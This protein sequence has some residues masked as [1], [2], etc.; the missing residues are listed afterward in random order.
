MKPPALPSRD[1][2]GGHG[3]GPFRRVR[4]GDGVPGF[5]APLTLWLSMIAAV[6]L[7]ARAACF[8]HRT[9]SA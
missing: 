3:P 9:V 4:V 5:S 7:A 2:F 6:G 8:R 1:L